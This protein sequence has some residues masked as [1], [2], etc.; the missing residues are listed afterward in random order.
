M[1]HT[2]MHIE[3]HLLTSEALYNI[4]IVVET[5]KDMPNS[6]QNERKAQENNM[7]I[8]VIKKITKCIKYTLRMIYDE[9]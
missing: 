3:W 6:L 7:H 9:A 8:L 1:Y 5:S 4:A 2:T